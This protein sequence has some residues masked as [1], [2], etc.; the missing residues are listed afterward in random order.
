MMM[1][2]H[3]LTSVGRE[4]LNFH[5]LSNTSPSTKKLLLFDRAIAWFE[6]H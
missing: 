1:I 4:G 6:A 3:A 5:R 2:T